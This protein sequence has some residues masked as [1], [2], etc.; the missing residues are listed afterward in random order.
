[1]KKNEKDALY[2]CLL[3]GFLFFIDLVLIGGILWRGHANFIELYRNLK[4]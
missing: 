2:V 1:M 3:L 4:K